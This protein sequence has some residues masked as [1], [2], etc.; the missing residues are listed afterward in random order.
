MN[1]KYL[2]RLDDACE[3]MN[4][5]KWQR[6]EDLLDK[7]EIKPM[8][9]VIPL[10][11]DKAFNHKNIGRDAFWNKV[12]SWQNK[13]WEIAQHGYTHEYVAK[14]SGDFIVGNNYSEFA[15]LLYEIQREK[16]KKGYAVFQEQ[17][18]A[19][20]SWIAPA[21]TFDADTVRALKEESDISIISDSYALF[22]YTKNGFTWI[23]V[24][25]ANFRKFPFGY[26]TIC[27]HPNEFE[28]KDFIRLEKGI[29]QF[30]N[31]IIRTDEVKTYNG[32]LALFLNQLFQM[33]FNLAIRYKRK[34]YPNLKKRTTG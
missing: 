33:S 12:K 30:K 7:Y 3:T 11:K 21:H 17:G 28:E 18:I 24:Q 13:D 25:I 4:H 16:I 19:V 15:G 2:V 29:Q 6:M 27:L 10:N 26:W 22:P 5:E 8:V 23:P 20:K 9:A 34:F 32:F 1:A 14:S 31:Q